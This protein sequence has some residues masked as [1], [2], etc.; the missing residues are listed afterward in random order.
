MSPKQYFTLNIS[1]KTDPEEFCK[2]WQRKVPEGSEPFDVKTLFSF[3]T[4]NEDGEQSEITNLEATWKMYDKLE[5]QK[6]QSDYDNGTLP[7]IKAGTPLRLPTSELTLIIEDAPNK[8]SRYN[9]AD[10]KLLFSKH[11]N[12]IINDPGYVSYD[13]VTS[14]E[15]E[16]GWSTKT[17]SI[18]AKV[19]LY[20]KS[21]KSVVDISPFISGL[22]TDKTIEN[23]SF[24][25]SLLPIRSTSVQ[26]YGDTYFETFNIV[27]GNQYTVKSF[28]EKFCQFNDIIFIRFEKLKLESSSDEKIFP[29]S[30]SLIVDKEKLT[31]GTLWDM[32]GFVDKCSISLSAEENTY[33]ISLSG[34]GIEKLLED[35]GS[36]FLPL[37]DVAGSSQFAIVGQAEQFFQRNSLT[38][39]YDF[40]GA[41]TFKRIIDTIWF[42]FNV[43]SNLGV[44]DNDLFSAWKDKRVESF[45]IDGVRKMEVNGIWQ[46]VNVYADQSCSERILVDSSFG[47]PNGTLISLVQRICQQPFVE[48]FFDTY[49][50]TIDMTI[51]QPPFNR[52]AIEEIVDNHLYV[53]IEADSIYEMNLD[54]DTR[55]YSWYQIYAQNAWTAN[56]QETALAMVP[57][58][59][60]PEYAEYFGNKKLEVGDMYLRVSKTKDNSWLGNMVNYQQ[61]ALNDLLYII[62][63]SAYLPFTRRGTIILHGDRRIKVGTFI[64]N[65]ATDELFYVTG[66]NNMVEFSDS[67]IER[68]TTLTVERGMNMTILEKSSME[69]TSSLRKDNSI[70]DKTKSQL[71]FTSSFKPDYFGIVDTEWLKQAIESID[72]EGNKTV[73]LDSKATVVKEQFEYFLNRKMFEQ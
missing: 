41:Y 45:P 48:F 71:G 65:N 53:D 12:D 37:K 73:T 63:S 6:Y 43:C 30:E 23:S 31:E 70:G 3:P 35:D 40:I 1:K 49:K 14:T 32:I 64:R 60:L 11:Y 58:V 55:F 42:I 9:Q 20:C 59:Y 13:K 57:I 10:Y 52:K 28:L 67:S 2:D 39:T 33:N 4:K 46:I 22:T 27:N 18:N 56:T 61:A 25:L 38:G 8:D 24:E 29:I 54:Y 36:Y 19:Y 26:K 17:A 34:R 68:R 15:V 62:E 5:K 50:D 51:R 66:V 69:V 44:V 7:Y 21:I 72:K 47:N 16:K